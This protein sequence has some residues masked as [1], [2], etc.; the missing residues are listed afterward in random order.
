MTPFEPLNDD[1]LGE[2]DAWLGQ[3]SE[4]LPSAEALDGF[5]TAIAIGPECNQFDTLISDALVDAKAAISPEIRSLL[6]RHFQEVLFCVGPEAELEEL[7]DWAPLFFELDE[8]VA[9]TELDT[10]WGGD[11]AQG[12]RV[13]IE[14][15]SKMQL[16]LG[17]VEGAPEYGPDEIDP[18]IYLG[19]MMALESGVDPEN[20]QSLTLAELREL[21][22]PLIDAIQAL[23]LYFNPVEDQD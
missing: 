15:S 6:V 18:A 19:T 12:F 2:I 1:E 13:A 4:D 10:G 22:T 23:R 3:N 9:E 11:W 21:E 16:A 17:L 5:C 14:H 7:T 8:D 20:E